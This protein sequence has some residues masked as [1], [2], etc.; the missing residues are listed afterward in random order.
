MA[1]PTLDYS[2]RLPP[3]ASAVAGLSI[4]NSAHIVNASLSV[5]EAVTLANQTVAI[6]C[7]A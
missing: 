4:C 3:L 6:L 2:R 7:P 5:N 1:L